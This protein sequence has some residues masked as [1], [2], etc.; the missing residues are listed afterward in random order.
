M[1][2]GFD[3]ISTVIPFPKNCRVDENYL[4]PCQNVKYWSMQM[5][6]IGILYVYYDN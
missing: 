6:E 2:A 1:F 5:S 3:T 4:H